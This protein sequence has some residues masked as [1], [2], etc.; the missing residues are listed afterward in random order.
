VAKDLLA[1]TYRLDDPQWAATMNWI[2][3]ALIQ[4]EESGITQGNLESMKKSD[5][6]VIARLLGTLHGYGQYLGLDDSWAARMI[7]AVGNY[8]ELYDRD[9]GAGSVM[10][11]DRGANILVYS[12][13]ENCCKAVSCALICVVPKG[14][15]TLSRIPFISAVCQCLFEEHRDLLYAV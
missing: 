8:G 7:Q 5:D 12:D 15:L 9:L 11:L 2:A 10:K 3:D 1:I 6:P 13:A 14:R 4:A